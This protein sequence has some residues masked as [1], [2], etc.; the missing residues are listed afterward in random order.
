MSSI[1]AA[2]LRYAQR[3]AFEA[4]KEMDAKRPII[5]KVDEP[6]PPE[7]SQEPCDHAH[8]LH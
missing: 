7:P 1:E 3:A 2:Y 8:T 6:R 5:V 4:V